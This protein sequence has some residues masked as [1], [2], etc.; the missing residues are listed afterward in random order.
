MNASI[1]KRLEALEAA[2]VPPIPWNEIMAHL[3]LQLRCMDRDDLYQETPAELLP[4]AEHLI[5]GSLEDWLELE[6]YRISQ[7]EKIFGIGSHAKR[8]DYRNSGEVV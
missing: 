1:L 6:K 4:Y 5:Y 8:F 7:Y 2:L 3:A